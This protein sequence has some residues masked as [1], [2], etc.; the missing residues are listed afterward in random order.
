MWSIFSVNVFV[1]VNLFYFDPKCKVFQFISCIF[2]SG[3][4]AEPGMNLHEVPI[5]VLTCTKTKRLTLKKA[6]VGSVTRDP[7]RSAHRFGKLWLVINR[8]LIKKCFM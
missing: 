2:I 7:E 8:I 4:G 5:A 6:E 3:A 1:A